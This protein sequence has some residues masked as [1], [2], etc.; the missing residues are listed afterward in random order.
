MIFQEGKKRNC[1][2]V[3]NEVNNFFFLIEKKSHTNLCFSKV[4]LSIL[5]FTC[6][7]VY[8]HPNISS[9]WYAD[10][11]CMQNMT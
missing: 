10:P 4:L 6:H 5:S 1:I 7:D 9:L 2:K 11:R 8:N 3:P